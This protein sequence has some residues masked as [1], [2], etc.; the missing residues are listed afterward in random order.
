[1][2][3]IVVTISLVLGAVAITALIAGAVLRSR[4]LLTL[5]G[6]LLASLVLTW[7][8]GLLGLPIGIFFGFLGGGIFLRSR[9]KDGPPTP[10][11]R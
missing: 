2:G 3:D 11:D 4:A 7:I 9:P 8:L 6:S 5:G 1:M 10:P